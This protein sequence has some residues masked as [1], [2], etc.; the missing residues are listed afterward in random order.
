MEAN[1]LTISLN[2]P[3]QSRRQ[4]AYVVFLTLRRPVFL[5]NSS[6]GHFSA[7]FRG[8]NT[9]TQVLLLPKLRSN[10]A[11][12]LHESYLEPL[13]LLASHTSVSLWY[14]HYWAMWHSI[15]LVSIA[16]IASPFSH[17]L[18]S[19]FGLSPFSPDFNGVCPWRSQLTASPTLAT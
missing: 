10:F 9:T 7:T 19:D 17:G 12:F 13:R 5:I 6:L 3:A 14:G 2:L 16:V 11:E 1:L 4:S 15:F 18:H 8:F